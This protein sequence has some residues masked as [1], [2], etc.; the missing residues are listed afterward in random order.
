M[1]HVLALQIIIAYIKTSN[2]RL[3][4]KFSTSNDFLP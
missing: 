1:I 3:A 2:Y 4:E